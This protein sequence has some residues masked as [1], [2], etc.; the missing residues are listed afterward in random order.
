MPTSRQGKL[1]NGF[2]QLLLF[3]YGHYWRAPLARGLFEKKEKKKRCKG[4]EKSQKSGMVQKKTCRARKTL[5]NAALVAKI[6]VDTAENEQRRL[7][8]RHLRAFP[9]RLRRASEKGAIR[10]Q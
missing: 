9:S 1:E 3:S 7:A 10:T 6:G 8:P 5:K 4:S 2:L